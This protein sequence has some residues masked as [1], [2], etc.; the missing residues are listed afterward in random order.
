MGACDSLGE[1]RP[2]VCPCYE[3][4][5]GGQTCV[6]SEGLSDEGAGQTGAGRGTAFGQLGEA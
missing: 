4:G 5:H 6:D 3:S 1:L 2:S